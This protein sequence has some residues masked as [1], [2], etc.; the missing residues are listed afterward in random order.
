MLIR[1]KILESFTAFEHA[2]GRGEWC[3]EK[4]AIRSGENKYMAEQELGKKTVHCRLGC[5]FNPGIFFCLV[6]LFDHM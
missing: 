2:R 6:I 3:G 4:K 1:T 5:K